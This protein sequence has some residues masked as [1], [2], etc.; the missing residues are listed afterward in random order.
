MEKEEKQEEKQVDKKFIIN[1]QG[2]EFI[3]FEGLLDL[4]HQMN[5]KSINTELVYADYEK[6]RFVFKA[7]A[8]FGDGLHTRLFVGHGDADTHNTGDFVRVHLPRMAETRA[9]ARALRL[10]CN[11]GMCSAEELGGDSPASQ[12]DKPPT[13]AD[14]GSDSDKKCVCDDC[15]KTISMKVYQYSSDKMGRPLCMD[16]QK[17]EKQN[18]EETVM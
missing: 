18:K 2:K 8:I 10:G 14:G 4:A 11:I 6:Q 9:V 7:T 3:K 5:L 15:G 1:L 16:C 13:T 12:T 17:S